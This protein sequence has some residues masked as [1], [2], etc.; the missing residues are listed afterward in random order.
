MGTRYAVVKGVS[1]AHSAAMKTAVTNASGT[2]IKHDLVTLNFDAS[3]LT[4]ANGATF[5]AAAIIIDSAYADVDWDPLQA[6][7]VNQG[8]V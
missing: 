1:S 2:F 8:Q 6:L 3:F 4:D 5:I 7:R